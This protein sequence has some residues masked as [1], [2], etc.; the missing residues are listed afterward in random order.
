MLDIMSAAHHEQI[1]KGN[2]C[3][4]SQEE[5]GDSLFS[6]KEK[7]FLSVFRSCLTPK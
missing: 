7:A 1:A 3:Q 6:E 2:V 5:E 4:N